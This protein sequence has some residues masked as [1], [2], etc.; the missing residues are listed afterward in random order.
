M[1]NKSIKVLFFET[2]YITIIIL[3]NYKFYFCI[4]CSKKEK[5]QFKKPSLIANDD[6][7]DDFFEEFNGNKFNFHGFPAD[8]LKQFEEV[9]STMDEIDEKSTV[10]TSEMF[11]KDFDKKYNHFKQIDRD[12]DGQIYADQL[13][14]LLKRVSPQ[15]MLVNPQE[16]TQVKP[17]VRLTDDEKIMDMI[18][19][20]YKEE[21]VISKPRKRSVQKQ[22]P[23]VPKSFNGAFEGAIAPQH[24]ARSWGRTVISITKPDGVNLISIKS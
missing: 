12:L 8:I 6:E 9:L 11:K 5:S 19:G 10:E 15:L 1:L 20:T 22:S 7:D 17:K 23:S 18:H 16:I 13:D 24:H 2:S 21:I 14:S 3:T 4:Y